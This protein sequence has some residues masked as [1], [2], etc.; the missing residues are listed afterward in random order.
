MIFGSSGHWLAGWLAGG[1][2]SAVSELDGIYLSCRPRWR[3][4]LLVVTQTYVRILWYIVP[5]YLI[6]SIPSAPSRIEKIS[7]AKNHPVRCAAAAVVV[8]EQSPRRSLF[9]FRFLTSSLE[10]WSSKSPILGGGAIAT[11]LPAWRAVRHWVNSSP[12]GSSS[13]RR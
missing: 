12:C 3:V 11:F 2:T 4:A 13:I 10:V 5:M 9:F 1:W 7:S 6:N 8:F